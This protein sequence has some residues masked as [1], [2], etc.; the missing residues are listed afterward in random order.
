MIGPDVVIH[1]NVKIGDNNKI[2]GNTIIHPNT[3]IG[4][5]NIIFPSNIIGELP[6]S[7]YTICHDYD[8]SN[9]LLKGV[10]IGNHNVLYNENWIQSGLRYKTTIENNNILYGKI[11]IGHDVLIK[12]NTSI[13]TDSILGGN[14]I[15]MDNSTIG[16]R[17]AIIQNVVIGNYS[18]IG[19]NNT[20]TKNIFPF[21]VNINNEI[22]RINTKKTPQN[23]VIYEKKLRDIYKLFNDNK[24]DIDDYDIPEDIYKILKDYTY[25]IENLKR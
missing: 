11:K 21:F 18:M 4:D 15:F 8:F 1:D 2:Y 22:K 24:Y 16:M 10:R 5:N 9:P 19:L 14:S 3:E 17:A 20:I 13:H 25:Y 12:N 7:T 6:T 23:V